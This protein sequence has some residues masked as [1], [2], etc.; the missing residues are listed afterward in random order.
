MSPS[1]NL[2]AHRDPQ[3]TV[4][5]CLS[6]SVALQRPEEDAAVHRKCRDLAQVGGLGGKAL[7]KDSF[8]ALAVSASS[9]LGSFQ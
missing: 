2:Q 3:P 4:R 7:F 9:V 5:L 8:Y 1:S 6:A